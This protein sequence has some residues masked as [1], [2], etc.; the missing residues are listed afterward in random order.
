MRRLENVQPMT[1]TPL[2]PATMAP[3]TCVY[4]DESDIYRRLDQWSYEQKSVC[5]GRGA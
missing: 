1:I 4:A 2:I 3:G 5:H